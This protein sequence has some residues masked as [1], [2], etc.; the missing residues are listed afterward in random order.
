MLSYPD[1][2]EAQEKGIERLNTLLKD[3]KVSLNICLEL[4]NSVAHAVKNHINSLEMQLAGCAL[5]LDIIGRGP[6]HECGLALCLR[7]RPHPTPPL[8][9]LK[10][11]TTS[12]SLTGKPD[13][14]TGLVPEK[15]KEPCD[16]DSGDE[17]KDD[18]IPN[19]HDPPLGAA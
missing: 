12:G 6:S 11:G 17:E 10:D 4:V 5:L 7:Q 18:L 13:E 16:P 3:A 9:C 14:G 1:I 8:T 15:D 19:R 2:E